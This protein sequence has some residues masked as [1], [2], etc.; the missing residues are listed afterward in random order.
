MRML[1]I[2][3]G[4]VVVGLSA[5]GPAQPPKDKPKAATPKASVKTLIMQKKLTQAQKLLEGIVIQDFGKIA[6]SAAE[7]SELRKDAAW[8]VMRTP[9][10][11]NFSI[12]FARSID[13]AAR[14]AKN[15]NTDAAALAYVD[16][17]LIC[18]KCHKY[19]RDAG[20]ARAVPLP[21]QI[22][23]QATRSP[24]V[25]ALGVEDLGRDGRA[26]AFDE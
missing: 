26:A 14:A 19:V 24:P 20:I 15:K 25:P 4:L 10:Y 8:M 11:D 17:T 3:C 7:L 6:A 1:A 18:V 12:E 21:D 23:G 5:R 13:A 22:G 2:G 16:M 9:D